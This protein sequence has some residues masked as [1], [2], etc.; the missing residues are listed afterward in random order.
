MIVPD[1]DGAFLHKEV[2]PDDP[3]SDWLWRLV[4]DRGNDWMKADF[5]AL[6]RAGR[7]QLGVD[8]ARN[9]QPVRLAANYVIFH[10][11]QSATY[12]LA[13]P[14]VVAERDP[15]TADSPN[16]TWLDSDVAARL[17]DL[18]LARA[19]GTR[20]FLRTSNTGYPHPPATLLVDAPTWPR[21]ASEAFGELGFGRWM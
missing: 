10:H 16:E 4:C 7:V 17:Y 15:T 2:H 6:S 1:G 3:H 13:E 9:G 20:R 18:T 5:A 12:I 8:T 11:S 19:K 21:E 14:P